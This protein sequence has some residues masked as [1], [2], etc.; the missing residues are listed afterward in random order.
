MEIYNT[1]NARQNFFKIMDY[2]TKWHEPIYVVGK[3]SKAV[4][5]SEEEYRSIMETMYI[6]SV[7]GL[8]N[9]FLRLA[10]LSQQIFY[11]LEIW[12]RHYEKNSF[13]R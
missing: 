8:K 9:Q 7:P 3:N 10:I 1:S 13:N 11:N 12:I 6:C 4:I 2:V 5:M